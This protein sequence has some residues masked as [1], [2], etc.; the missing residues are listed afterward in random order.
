MSLTALGPDRIAERLYRYD[1]AHT[2]IAE[3]GLISDRDVKDYWQNGFIAVE[4][5]FSPA[6]V[7]LGIDGLEFLIHG[8]NP[9]FT[10]VH[11]EDV[12]KDKQLSPQEKADHVRK[13]MRFVDYDGRLKSMSEHP[14][15][16]A[17]VKRL[18][19]CDVRLIQDMALIK[20]P[21]VGREKPWHQDNAYFVWEPIDKVIGTWTALD[22]ATPENGCMHVLPGTHREGPRPHY[23]DRDCQLNDEDVQVD[24]DVMVPLKPGGVLFFS[25]LLHHGTPPNR[26]S[27]R[28]RALQF[29]YCWEGCTK[30]NAETHAS[31][32]HDDHAYA[33][34]A[35][36]HFK[37][38][39]LKN[40]KVSE[41]DL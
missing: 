20:P 37:E 41:K 34:C 30:M 23:H 36:F 7:Q 22:A 24:R 8:G 1:R 33:G 4:N 11:V 3:P 27:L 15:L 38:A 14:I 18:L 29:H 21:L 10:G 2:P 40:R 32:F 39:G 5:V 13:I 25:S 35:A 19:D 16:L 26:S 28:R 12:S 17:I 6:E 9:R 31:L